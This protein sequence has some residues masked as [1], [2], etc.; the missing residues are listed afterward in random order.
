MSR[1][2]I[3][4]CV[5]IAALACTTAFAAWGQVPAGSAATDRLMSGIVHK[6][7]GNK[8]TLGL[9]TG[10]TVQVDASNAAKAEKLVTLTEG[11]AV[12]AE[13]TLDKAGILHAEMVN[14]IKSA[15]AMWPEDR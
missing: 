15:R 2:S 9:R 6:I 10:K 8:F 13:G 12:S 14:R 7:D 11:L 4:A 3:R 1:F 5:A